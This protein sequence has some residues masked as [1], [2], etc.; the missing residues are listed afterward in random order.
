MDTITTS[1]I[2]VL[3]P[4]DF[5]GELAG[6]DRY[7]PSHE[8]LREGDSLSLISDTT[9]I[10][11]VEAYLDLPEGSMRE[12]MVQHPETGFISITAKPSYG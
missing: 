10:A 2:R 9:L 8:V 3:F 6:Q 5:H 1:Q 11:R 4:Q 12:L 7:I